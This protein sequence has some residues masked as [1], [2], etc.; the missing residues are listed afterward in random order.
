MLEKIIRWRTWLFNTLISSLLLIGELLIA[1]DTGFNWREVIPPQYVPW[2][3]IAILAANIWMRPR[4]AV[5]PA[6]ARDK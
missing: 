3:G 1:L 2:V 6:E 5:L 4:P